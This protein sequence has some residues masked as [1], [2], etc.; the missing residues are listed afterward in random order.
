MTCRSMGR[1]L[2]L[3][4]VVLWAACGRQ[5][6]LSISGTTP[7]PN[8]DAAAGGSAGSSVGGSMDAIGPAVVG[9]S[10]ASQVGGAVA[11]GGSGGATTGAVGG[12]SLGGS[13]GARS[14]MAGVT[15]S[16]G[17]TSRGG[18]AAVSGGMPSGGGVPLQGGGGV[19]GGGNSRA[20]TG[21]MGGASSGGSAGGSMGGGGTARGGTTSSGGSAGGS[22]GGGG[23]ARGGMTSS[24]G[25]AGGSMGGG[26]TARGGTNSSTGTVGSSGGGTGGGPDGGILASGYCTGD[27]TKVTY[28]G[29]TVSAP[30]TNY[31]SGLAFDCCM[32][33]GVN[34]HTSASLGL[35]FQV[36]VVSSVGV[37][38]GD[39]EVGT[40]SFRVRASVGTSNESAEMATN[41]TSG[42]VHMGSAPMASQAW[43]LGLCL[44]VVD[45]SSDLLGTRIYVPSVTMMPYYQWNNRFQ[46]YLLHDP[47]LTALDAAQ[48][49]LDSLVL[50]T[51][52]LLDLSRIA[53]VEQ[54]TT[55]IGLNPGQKLG[56]SI[57]TEL[58]HPLGLPFV[59]VADGVRIYL[60]TFTS[61]VSSI[62]PA[63][64]YIMMDDIT[65]DGLVIQPPWT[66][67]DPRND[68]RILQV[69]TEAGK[70]VP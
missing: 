30:A 14:S 17:S 1:Q 45:T 43:E 22:A 3:A 2:L 26:G 18:S 44:E 56:D 23:T 39:Y 41:N 54:A 64:P 42:N 51:L 34:L 19:A 40:T 67:T 9:G 27:G 48:L 50:A 47:S 55:R 5:G 53:Y 8:Q 31:Q 60:G 25:S 12:A 70:L 13:A 4:V 37:S 52:P 29:Q 10:T 6:G 63:G 24:G 58:G 21:A 38:P 11:G 16:G 33:Y 57:H 36:E 7:V 32:A 28:L 62:T 20:T 61:M 46:V 59:V 68:P 66:G 69:L 49:A 65:S 15:A 35:D